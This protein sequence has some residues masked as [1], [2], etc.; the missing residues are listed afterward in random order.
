MKKEGNRGNGEKSNTQ[1]T[2]PWDVS[3]FEH[4]RRVGVVESGGAL[5]SINRSA[6]PVSPQL[7]VFLYPGRT[8]QPWPSDSV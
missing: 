3:T 2:I 5:Y 8:N 7:I 4:R 6:R 1:A